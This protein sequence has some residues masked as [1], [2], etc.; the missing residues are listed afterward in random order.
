VGIYSSQTAVAGASR[1]AF[2][3]A[4]ARSVSAV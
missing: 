4:V 3:P 1:W 2:S